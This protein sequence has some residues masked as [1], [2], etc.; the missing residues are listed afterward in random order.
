MSNLATNSP[1]VNEK[2][3]WETI[4]GFQKQL[5][6]LLKN[7]QLSEDFT[8]L[9]GY[10]TFVQ[11]KLERLVQNSIDE[12]Q[13]CYLQPTSISS[14]NNFNDNGTNNETKDASITINEKIVPLILDMLWDKIYYPIFKWFQAWKRHLSPKSSQEQPKYVE[15]RKMNSKFNKFFSIVHK[16]YYLTIELLNSKY[17]MSTVISNKIIKDLN[18]PLFNESKKYSKPTKL[19]ELKQDSK[20]TVLVV[21]SFHRCVL[22]L[23]SAQR[24]RTMSEKLFDRFSV[25]DF[26]K[27]FRYLDI[28]SLLLPS[29]GE[30]H[31]QKSLIYLNTNNFGCATYEFIRCSLSRIPNQSGLSM[32]KTMM[33]DK[34][35]IIR[36][37]FDEILKSTQVYEISGSKIVNRE[38]I[39]YYFLALFGCYFAP[40]SWTKENSNFEKL[41]NDMNLKYL[42]RIYYERMSTRYIKN[43][44]LIFKNLIILIGGYQLLINE[45]NKKITTLNDLTNQLINYLNF[46][47]EF[48]S[49]LIENVI[50][51]AWCKDIENWEYL[52]IIRIIE[53]WI[54]SNKIIL[55]FSHRNTKFC[56]SLGIFLNEIWKSEKLN[57]ETFSKH[58]PKRNYYFE[59]DV[60]LKEFSCINNVLTD[61][62]DNEIF[63]T[64]NKSDRLIGNINKEEK[65]TI[66][67][68]NQLRLEAIVSSGYKFLNNNSYGVEWNNDKHIYEFKNCKIEINNNNITNNYIKMKSTNNNETIFSKKN[69]GFSKRSNGEKLIAVTELENKLQ[70]IRNPKKSPSTSSAPTTASSFMNRRSTEPWGYS[71]SSVPMAPESFTIRPSSALTSKKDDNVQEDVQMDENEVDTSDK[72]EINDEDNEIDDEKETSNQK[73]ETEQAQLNQDIANDE[74]LSKYINS[75][76][77]DDEDSDEEVLSFLQPQV[78][79]TCMSY[80]NIS[81]SSS[82]PYQP[83]YSRNSTPNKSPQTSTQ[84]NIRSSSTNN[85]NTESSFPFSMQFPSRSNTTT[86]GSPYIASTN[87]NT[88]AS[89]TTTANTTASTSASTSTTQTHEESNN[90]DK[91]NL[92]SSSSSFQIPFQ[93]I[94]NTSSGTYS[95]MNMNMTMSPMGIPMPMPLTTNGITTNPETMYPNVSQGITT[96]WSDNFF[97]DANRP[98]PPPPPQSIYPPFTNNSMNMAMQNM[99]PSPNRTTSNTST[100]TTSNANANANTNTSFMNMNIRMG[101][102]MGMNMNMQ[103]QMP[104]PPPPQGPLF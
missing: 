69:N 79:Q 42:K 90:T 61:F 25:Q 62:N 27:A 100:T 29:V 38:I 63:S 16:F 66:Q 57:F 49:N 104:R 77:Q 94:P 82:L 22:Y 58:R 81:V 2:Y 103:G 65:L 46:T 71:G 96:S 97:Q 101:M 87:I 8:L 70:Q 54:K 36:E 37:K 85:T 51:P 60:I 23:G 53:C 20:F 43:I 32:F 18:L 68:E 67:Q 88:V 74:K 28:A 11:S 44:Q 5:H 13:S 95:N 41:Y 86:T 93:Q 50:K 6:D 31:L 92:S 39:E 89:A 26:K 17:D 7:N 24:Y 72:L 14:D 75:V 45:Q 102:G 35:S 78:Q 9:N 47:F 64:I 98:Y 99:V 10:L 80:N 56:K 15:F 40:T 84:I 34:N 12:Q 48:I 83:I 33:F 19:I 59:E 4:T 21:V 55:L 1:S 73:C 3:V 52:A 91:S 76:L 30:P